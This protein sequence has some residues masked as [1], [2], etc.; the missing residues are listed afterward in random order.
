MKTYSV[1]KPFRTVVR[2][3]QPQTVDKETN[4][5]SQTIVDETLEQELA[6]PLTIAV[7][8][9]QGFLAEIEP[10]EQPATPAPATVPPAEFSP[11]V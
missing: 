11:A 6:F 7:L 4:E 3:L 8:L 10:D 5:P 1:E 9:E 2:D